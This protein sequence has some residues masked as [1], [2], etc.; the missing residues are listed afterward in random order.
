MPLG[1]SSGGDLAMWG[2]LA[3]VLVFAGRR[4]IRT[5]VAGL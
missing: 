4:S 1:R 3:M 5:R 2:F